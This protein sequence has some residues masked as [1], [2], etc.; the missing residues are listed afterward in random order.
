MCG[1]TNML[2]LLVFTATGSSPNKTPLL[3]THPIL[4]VCTSPLLLSSY[5][6]SWHD[7]KK[8][9]R[10]VPATLLVVAK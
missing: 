1:A 4:P 9:I 6:N 3:P 2:L 8:T 7:P 10:G 5:R